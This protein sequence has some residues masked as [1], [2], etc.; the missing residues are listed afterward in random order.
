MQANNLAPRGVIIIAKVW[1]VEKAYLQRN[2]GGEESDRK[3]SDRKD[4]KGREETF[5]TI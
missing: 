2:E 4:P 1:N 3:G 5:A